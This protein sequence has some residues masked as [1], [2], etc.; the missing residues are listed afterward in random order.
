[1]AEWMGCGACKHLKNTP[2]V[3]ASCPA[4]PQGIPM[5]I[6]SGDTSHLTKYPTQV[7]DTVF[8]PKG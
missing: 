2:G 4:F 6:A 5:S 3:G 8:E 1:M 7:G